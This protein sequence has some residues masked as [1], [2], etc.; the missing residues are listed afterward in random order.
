[1]S[2][3]IGRRLFKEALMHII[4]MRCGMAV[5]LRIVVEV[6]IERQQ[7]VSIASSVTR[8]DH[9]VAIYI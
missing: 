8:N 4:S 6:I 3:L 5:A 1:M 9:S 7:N 2:K